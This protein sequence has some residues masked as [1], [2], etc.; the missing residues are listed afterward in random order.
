MKE[1][2]NKITSAGEIK[3]RDAK[4][5]QRLNQD[6]KPSEGTTR[7]LARNLQPDA[8]TTKGGYQRLL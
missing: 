2:I 4:L 5:K 3:E 6:P 1:L 7:A 8:V